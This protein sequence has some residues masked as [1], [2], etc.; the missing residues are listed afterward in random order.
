[1]RNK[2][3]EKEPEEPH[4]EEIPDRIDDNV[5]QPTPK[6]WPTNTFPFRQQTPP[7]VI[8]NCSP[9]TLPKAFVNS[10]MAR[11]PFTFQEQ[12]P[13]QDPLQETTPWREGDELGAVGGLGWSER[14]QIEE[15]NNKDW[16]KQVQNEE[17]NED[18]WENEQNE[19]T[20]EWDN[21]EFN[22]EEQLWQPR[23]QSAQPQLN[24][25]ELSW[26]CDNF[27]RIRFVPLS[28]T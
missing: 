11:P 6:S 1:M 7:S 15:L 3:K 20:L 25:V 17:L 8:V 18:T 10:T 14:V 23:V 21:M 24:S 2:E 26:G 12:A 19:D 16:E 28:G 4:Y 5:E 22:W 9:D 13:R 27:A